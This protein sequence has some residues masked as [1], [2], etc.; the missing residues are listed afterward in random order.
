MKGSVQLAMMSLGLDGTLVLVGELDL[1]FLPL[2]SPLPGNTLRLLRKLEVFLGPIDM[3]RRKAA[4][5]PT[6]LCLQVAGLC[7]LV[8]LFWELTF[9]WAAVRT[10][11]SHFQTLLLLLIRNSSLHFAQ[12]HFPYDS[13]IPCPLHAHPHP[14]PHAWD[15]W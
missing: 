9:L 1:F 14:L 7:I 6:H 8:P 4:Q 2:L 10:Y 3:H 12:R 11:F 13:T 15:L 5:K